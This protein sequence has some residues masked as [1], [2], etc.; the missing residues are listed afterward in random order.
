MKPIIEIIIIIIFN[1]KFIIL[2]TCVYVI[3]FFGSFLNDIHTPKYK[4]TSAV[5]Q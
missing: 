5:R 4:S 1:L 2:R 3:H